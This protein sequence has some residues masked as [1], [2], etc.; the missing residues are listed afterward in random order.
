[1]RDEE[2]VFNSGKKTIMTKRDI[3]LSK[4][5]TARSDRVDKKKVGRKNVGKG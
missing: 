1:M 3:N 4:K 2:K 5:R